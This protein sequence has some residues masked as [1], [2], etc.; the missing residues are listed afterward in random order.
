[1]NKKEVTHEQLSQYVNYISTLENALET[2]KRE[3]SKNTEDQIYFD[4]ANGALE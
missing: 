4:I 1:M 2:I 3:A